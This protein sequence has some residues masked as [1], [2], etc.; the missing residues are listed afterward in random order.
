MAEARADDDEERMREPGGARRSAEHSDRNKPDQRLSSQG[1][2]SSIRAVIKRTSRTSSQSD[3]QRERRRPEITI[4]SA[5]PLPSNTWF[6][7]NSGAF[8]PAPPPA[9]PTW[10]ATAATVQLPPPSYEQVIREK[11]RE[12]NIPSSSSSSSRLS[13]CTIATQTDTHSPGPRSSA[14]RP[15]HKPPKPPRPSLPLKH[16]SDPDRSNPKPRDAQH[17]QCGVQTDFDDITG[18]ISPI[19]PAPTTKFSTQSDFD[20]IIGDTCDISSIGP[21]PTAKF[22]TQS[23][24]DD[25]TGDISPIGP[26]PTTKF[27]TLRD[28]DDIIGD[29]SSIDPA[30]TAK[31]STQSDLDDITGDI[32]PIGSAPSAKTFTQSNFDF[33]VEPMKEEARARPRPRPRSTVAL[34]PVVLD[35]PITREVK[36][37]TLVRLKDDG[38]DSVFAGF[39]DSPSNI[40]SKYLQDLLDVFGSDETHG[41][42]QESKASDVEDEKNMAACSVITSEPLE[43][44]EPL[45]RP[46]PRPRTQKSKPQLAPKPSVFD[47]FDTTVEQNPSK[48]LSPP[49]P[50]PRPLLNKLQSP[51]ESCSSTKPSP[52]TRPASSS[53]RRNSED[54]AINTPVKKTPVT[55][56]DRNVGKRSSVPKHSRPPPPVLRNMASPSQAAVDVSRA[57]NASVPPLP[58][59][60]S[61][62]RLLPLRPPPV[63]VAKPAGCA[64]SPTATNQ[65]PSSRAPKRAPPLPPRPK[66]GH[67]LYKRY[68]S[69][70]LQAETEEENISK[71]Q[72][73]PSEETSFHEEEQL[74]VLDD[75]DILETQSNTLHDLCPSEVKGQ[76]VTVSGVQLEHTPS[77]QQIQQNMQNSMH[78][79]CISFSLPL[80]RFVVARFAFEGGEGELTFSEGDVITLVEYAN[81]EWGRGIL[82]RRMGIFP[83]S[84]I[85]AK[86]ETDVLPG[87]PVLESPGGR[88][89]GRALYEFRPECEDE[90]CLKAG[91]IVCDLEDMD[92]EW[93]AGESGGKRG[94]VPKNYIQVLL[95]P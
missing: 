71:E 89:R 38:A 47:V 19:G 87:K 11:S 31:F 41:E 20:E 59:R 75:T 46:Q 36:V 39:D 49:V 70:V 27:S 25:I 82:N 78:N 45:N 14:A 44:L 77:E 35:Q 64:S 60:P 26:A 57:A 90:L 63:K 18:D 93:F 55:P 32:S 13:T 37:Q 16:T 42:S 12:Q 8:P 52:A 7:G 74:I 4:L 61:G 95:D 29:I 53:Q 43:P 34:R 56:T 84:F 50:A 62:G 9:P 51:S 80:S 10:A 85:Q 28:L 22:S 48:L 69:K 17:E 88:S 1:P 3:H 86:E 72:E 76:D 92:A 94:I 5:E 23:D 83:L 24:L 15:V 21:A 79:S 6:P 73:E 66:P 30:T 68:S 2:L 91:D 33:P 67:P 65:L 81:E 40:S 54:Q 58:P